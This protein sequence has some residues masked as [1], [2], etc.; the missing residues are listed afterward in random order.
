MKNT[1]AID[2][3]QDEAEERLAKVIC[4]FVRQGIV[5]IVKDRVT[6]YEIELTGG[7]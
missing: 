6:I 2:K 1:I 5:F 4:E 3:T 7:Y